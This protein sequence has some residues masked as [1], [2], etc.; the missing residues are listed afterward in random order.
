MV[1]KLKSLKMIVQ[2]VM[3]GG[4]SHTK[5]ADEYVQGLVDQVGSTEFKIIFGFLNFFL[6]FKVSSH[7]SQQT[8]K[9]YP[10][11]VAI[12]YKDQT[13]AGRNYFIKVNFKA[14]FLFLKARLKIFL[15]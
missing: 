4:T 5:P 11:L 6:I 13:V 7:I 3:V 12:S 2:P 15:A 14:Y 1:E 10:Q 9:S 8:G